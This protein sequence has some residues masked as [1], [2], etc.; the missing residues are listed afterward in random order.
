MHQPQPYLRKKPC[1]LRGARGS[2]QRQKFRYI[3]SPTASRC[4]I[5]VADSKCEAWVK[6]YESSLKAVGEEGEAR[7][8]RGLKPI[9][10]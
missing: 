9:G 8:A 6:E 2:V 1:P 4:R 3:K 7:M 10:A 5:Q